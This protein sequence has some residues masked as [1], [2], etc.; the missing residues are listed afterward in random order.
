MVIYF[1]FDDVIITIANV[2]D[3][4]DIMA[5]INLEWK[6]GHILARDEAFF[7]YE[8]QNNKQINFV[9]ARDK[10]RKNIIGI[11]GFIRYSSSNISDISTVIWKVIKDSN[12]PLF[13]IELLKFLQKTEYVRTLFSI[14]INYKTIGIYSY[15][16]MYTNYLKHFAIVNSNLNEFKIAKIG[17]LKTKINLIKFT[18]GLKV[19]KIIKDVKELYKFKFDNFQDYIPYKNKEYYL[20]RYFGHPIYKYEV[21]GVYNMD[22]IE[23][24]FVLRVDSF[25]EAR[26]IRVVDFLGLENNISIL[27]KF[28]TNLILKENYEYA[29][30]YCFG[31]DQD[32]LKNSGFHLIES[33]S[34]ELIIPNYFN[35]FVQKN[36]QIHFFA[37]TKDVH[38]LR[39]FKADGDQDRPS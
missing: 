24:L 21:F 30:F 38:L 29:D 28:L 33:N 9:V 5:F 22:E 18:T 10:K 7:R 39:F 27:A 19:V 32:N 8:H 3:I 15:L 2:N 25:N 20:K 12:S 14:G 1:K 13:G 17:D 36:I 26:V 31:L 34:D 11:L 6:E 35:P 4:K 23:T 16:G 37:N